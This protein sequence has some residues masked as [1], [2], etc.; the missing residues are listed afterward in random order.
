MMTMLRFLSSFIL[1][2]CFASFVDAQDVEWPTKPVRIVYPYAAGGVGDAIFRVIGPALESKF[3]QRFIVDNKTGADGKIGTL[4]VINAKPDGYTLLMA[5]TANYSVNQHLFTN[6]GFDPISLLEPISLI[7]EAP[8]IAVTSLTGPSSLKDFAQQAS[9]NP[10]KFNYGSPGTGSPPQLAGALFSQL[11]GNSIE[12]IAYRGTPPMVMAMMGG[13][14][15]LAFGSWSA[16]GTQIKAGKIKALATTGSQRFEEIL[17]VPTTK[18]SGY[19][20]LNI[21]NWWLLSAPKNTDPRIIQKL[22]AELK[23]IL[24]DS[25]T[26]VKMLEI[27]HTAIGLSPRESAAFIRSESAKYKSLIQKNSIKVD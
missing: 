12:H 18:E 11:A 3:G 7:A 16:V 8:L 15:Q 19:P 9:S 26:K 2:S 21:T 13:D 23:I 24:S 20:D 25:Q 10:N 1:F 6:L 22:Y 27:G 4:E 14:I 17:N 5:P